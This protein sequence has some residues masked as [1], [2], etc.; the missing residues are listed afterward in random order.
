MILVNAPLLFLIGALAAGGFSKNSAGTT[1]VLVSAELYT[2]LA[3]EKAR[4]DR[5]LSRTP[6]ACKSNS[7]VTFPVW[8]APQIVAI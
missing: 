5:R 4:A 8:R 7:G 6:M 2:P 3:P 1:I